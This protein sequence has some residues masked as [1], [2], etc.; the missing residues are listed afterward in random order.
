MRK[1]TIPTS[2]LKERICIETPLD[3]QTTNLI[4]KSCPITIDG[5]ELTADLIPLDMHDF[6]IILG[7]DWLCKNKANIDC[8]EK[9]I[10]LKPWDQ[11]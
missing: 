2:Q 10:S 3:S 11:N 6:D 7:M 1:Y 8:H 9:Q 4:C 5:W